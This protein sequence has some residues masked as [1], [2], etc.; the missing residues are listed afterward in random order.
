MSLDNRGMSGAQARALAADPNIATG[1]MVRLANGYPEVWEVLLKNPAVYPELRSWLE[2]A[3]ASAAAQQNSHL[4]TTAGVREPLA[5]VAAKPEVKHTRMPK[6]RRKRGKFFKFLGIFMPAALMLGGLFYA[7]DYA[8]QVAPAPGIITV[9]DI[10]AI[11][12]VGPW[13][14]D[15][16]VPTDSECT[17]YSMKTFKQDFAIVLIQNDLSKEKCR[18]LKKPT[19]STLALVNTSTGMESWKIDLAA[20]LE[21]TPKWRKEIVELPG[22]N[23]ILIRYIDINGQDANDDTKTAD[24]D[25]SAD[26]KMKTLVPYSALNGNI[27]DPVIA[28]S[29][30]QPPMKSVVIEVM[31]IPGHTKDVLLMTNGSNKDFRYA[32]YRAKTLTD[33]KWSYESDLKPARGNP[34]VG[35]NLILGREKDDEAKALQIKTG[36][37][38]AWNGPAGGSIFNIG[39]EFVHVTG[40]KDNKK[41]SNVESQ[42]G[43]KGKKTTIS[44]ISIT[45]KVTWELDCTG[46][47]LS[48][49]DAVSSLVS[50]T[51]EGQIYALSGKSNKTVSLIDPA[52]GDAMWKVKMPEAKFEI[53]R[54]SS[55]GFATAYLTKKGKSTSSSFVLISLADGELSE[56]VKIA[57]DKV[58]IDGMTNATGFVVDEPDRKQITA[59]LEDGETSATR[60][61]EEEDNSDEI[62]SCVVAL[63]LSNT[64]ELWTFD[65]NGNE[66]I[67]RAGGNWLLFDTTAGEEVIRPLAGAVE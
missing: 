48:R 45:G 62:R 27:T 37:V 47:A 7:V 19:P 8:F 12:D 38:S 40:D 14:Y 28:Q 46:Y 55:P 13:A 34:L 61:D 32:R 33:E 44:G 63:N 41:A 2:Q 57:G 52:N 66:H 53:S 11:P 60:D 10:R 58:R 51:Q 43:T 22:L 65:C 39:G 35:Q 31:P 23:E 24:D 1:V 36:K 67:S 59:D 29:K 50:R 20:E 21:W 30:A 6:R 17:E 9:Q 16:S 15:V 26:R 25:E 5:K 54:L 49:T 4:E 18:D 3:I 56:R 64:K 42:G